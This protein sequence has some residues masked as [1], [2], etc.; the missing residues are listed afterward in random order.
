MYSELEIDIDNLCAQLGF[1][2]YTS[3]GTYVMYTK[4]Y[5][6]ESENAE[7]VL[8]DLRAQIDKYN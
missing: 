8:K 4:Y 7:E 5:S 3:Y 1:V 2:G 6:I